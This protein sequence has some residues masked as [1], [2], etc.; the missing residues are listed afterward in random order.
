MKTLKKFEFKGGSDGRSSYDWDSI[1]SGEIVQLE[2]GKDFTCKPQ[3]LA[4]MARKQAKS[5]GMNVKIAKIEDGLV[6]QA[7][8]GG[9]SE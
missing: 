8:A 7:V 9:E 3:T 6:I 2:E 4:M 1:L 5:K